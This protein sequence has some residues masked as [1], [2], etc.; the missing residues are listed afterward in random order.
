MNKANAR[1]WLAEEGLEILGPSFQ[2]RYA[3]LPNMNAAF[4]KVFYVDKATGSDSQDGLTPAT[5]F[6]TVA[7][8]ITANNLEFTGLNYK[9]NT[10]Y[11]HSNT[12]S[13]ALTVMPHNCNVIGIGARARLGSVLTFTTAASNCNFWNMRFRQATA[14]PHV[15]IPD[16]C[17]GVSFHNCI[18]EGN[19]S[20]TYALSVGIC[21]DLVVEDCQFLG[22]PV[23]PTA[24]I[25][26]GLQIR[27]IIRRN[28]IAATTNGIEDAC[29]T[30]SY[31]GIIC[32]NYIGKQ[33]A[34]PNS[35]T[36]MAYGIKLDKTT[37]T[38]KILI[39]NNRIE[40]VDGIYSASSDTQFQNT[41][42]GNIVNEAG[43]STT[44]DELN[45]A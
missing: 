15:T 4:G 8:A 38:S 21:Q 7:K 44:E 9:M 6:A 40:A 23:F 31:G 20:A 11:V 2:T 19:G 17:Y 43:T 39:V 1:I 41:A 5:A 12:Y 14:A 16:N 25:L 36:Q 13:E 33:F 35:T 10:I 30:A 24:I 26:T 34:D 27:M 3:T 29:T 22:N 32:D 37:G 28:H 18:F 42:I 45:T